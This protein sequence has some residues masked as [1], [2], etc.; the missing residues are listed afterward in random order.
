M[1]VSERKK[2]KKKSL[3]GQHSEG[4]FNTDTVADTD[5]RPGINRVREREKETDTPLG[6]TVNKIPDRYYYRV[7]RVKLWKGTI[8]RDHT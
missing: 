5:R 7:L 8:G 2:T 4:K 3:F 6:H 1:C